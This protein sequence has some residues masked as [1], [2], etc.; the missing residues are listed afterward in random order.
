MLSSLV[1][2]LN[3]RGDYMLFTRG[4]SVF[5]VPFNQAGG[6]R[7]RRILYKPGKLIIPLVCYVCTP[8]DHLCKSS[9][10]LLF[11]TNFGGLSC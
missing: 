5:R 4:M 6:G 2:A 8:F 9:A 11:R 3:E 1:K 7:G 10:Y